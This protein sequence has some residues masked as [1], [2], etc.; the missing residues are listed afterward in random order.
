MSTY[1]LHLGPTAL[2]PLRRKACW[3]FFHPKNPTALAECKPANLGT[4][5]QHATSRPPKPFIGEIYCLRLLPLRWT[6]CF[7]SKC[8]YPVY[9]VEVWGSILVFP[10]TVVSTC[11]NIHSVQPWEL[12]NGCTDIYTWCKH[13]GK[14]RIPIMPHPFGG[15]WVTHKSQGNGNCNLLNPKPIRD[16]PRNLHF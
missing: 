10:K 9:N 14:A 4:K 5:D 8:W 2:L 12:N 1:T 3:G 7:P 6:P 16:F 15:L 11:Q 13:R